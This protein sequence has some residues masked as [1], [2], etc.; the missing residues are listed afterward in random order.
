MDVHC[1]LLQLHVS[2]IAHLLRVQSCGGTALLLQEEASTRSSGQTSTSGSGAS[3]SRLSTAEWR[4]KYET[5][6]M[7]DLWLED[8]FNAGSRLIVSVL[9][10]WSALGC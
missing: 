9:E 4:A 1:A 5:D 7:V 6:G 3:I 2:V 10:C 8:E